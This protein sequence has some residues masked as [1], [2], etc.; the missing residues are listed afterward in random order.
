MWNRT[1]ILLLAFMPL[2]AC[3]T[4]SEKPATQTQAL[5]VEE[6]VRRM[7][8]ASVAFDWLSARFSV[9]YIGVDKSQLGLGG[10]MRIR[11]DSA[12]W[13]SLSPMVGI[14]AA[15]A[16]ITHDSVKLLNR[17]NATYF[18]GG[19]DY[20]N[21]L[22]QT[23]IDYDILQALICGNDIPY[24][25][26]NVFRNGISGKYY[27]ITTQGRRKLKKHVNN[28]QELERVLIQDIFLDP[29]TFRVRRHEI[30]QLGQESR[31]LIATYDDFREV[32]GQL[33]PYQLRFLITV[34]GDISIDLNISKLTIGQEQKMPFTIP[35]TYQPVN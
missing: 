13:V 7:N 23:D 35:A 28:D 9:T 30:K 14:E 2:A 24:Y 26:E 20:I 22:I 19:L 34:D 25:E 16:L 5:E 3:R 18:L 15:R 10:Y 21:Q 32:E 29:E 1:L 17:L 31:K 8:E 11:D 27:H 12:V 6:V 33:F 4:S